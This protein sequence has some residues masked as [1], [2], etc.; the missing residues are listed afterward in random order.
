MTRTDVSETIKI[1][2]LAMEIEAITRN[3]WKLIKAKTSYSIK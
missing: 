3:K 2:K 1:S